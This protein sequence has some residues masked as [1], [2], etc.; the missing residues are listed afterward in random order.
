[1]VAYAEGVRVLDG[2]AVDVGA[3]PV[4]VAGDADIVLEVSA[5]GDG[6]LPQYASGGDIGL[7]EGDGGGNEDGG[8]THIEDYRKAR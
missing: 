1:M 6:R 3:T 7:C 4:G 5:S 8:E 2:D